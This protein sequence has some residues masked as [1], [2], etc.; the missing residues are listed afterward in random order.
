MP[1]S[2]AEL[3]VAYSDVA[4]LSPANAEP[5]IESVVPKQLSWTLGSA[6]KRPATCILNIA[7]VATESGCRGFVARACLRSTSPRSREPAPQLSCA[8]PCNRGCRAGDVGPCDSDRKP[9]HL[10]IHTESGHQAR[11]DKLDRQR[12]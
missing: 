11:Q 7:G 1:P 4:A 12:Q 3:L 5:K 10:P 6:L 2:C 9:D 8:I